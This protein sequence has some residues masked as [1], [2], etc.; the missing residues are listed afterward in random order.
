MSEANVGIH[1]GNRL[2]EVGCN[3]VFA[4]PGDFNL[5]LLDQL[6][7]NKELEMV[8]CCNELNAGYA[9]DGYARRKGIG[10]VVVT[11]CVGGF[12]VINAVSG[13]YSEDLPVICVSGGPNSNDFAS[14]HVL[15]HT[16]GLNN[17]YGQQVRAFREVTCCQ[18]IISH[19]EDAHRQIDLAVSE[20]VKHRKP[21]YIEISCNI[22][23]LFHPS[24]VRPAVPF[25]IEP[26]LS[27]KLSLDAAVDDIAK[28]LN[29]GVKPVLLVG[30]RLRRPEVQKAF[31]ALAEASQFPI[32][33]LPDAKGFVPED[34]PNFC[35]IYWG[36]VSAPCVC[37]MVESADLVVAVGCVWTDYSTV[38]Y[39][40]LLKN[41]KMIKIDDRHVTIQNGTTYSC[42][43]NIDVLKQLATK[44]KVNNTSFINFKR[45]YL[46][47]SEPAPLKDDEPITVNVLFN[48]VQK[49]LTADSSV[50]SEV[51]DSWFNTMK[52]KLPRGGTYELQM[53]YGS[54]GWSVGAVLGYQCADQQLD[55]KRRL[56]AFI[57]DGSFQMTVQEVSTMLR[58]NLKPIIFLI[59]N[60]GY[61]IEVEIHDGPYN[62]IK[63]WNYTGVIEAFQNGE[64]KLWTTKV[65]TEPEF[66]VAL[67]EAI[68][69]TDTL[70][71]IEVFVHKDDCSKE[72]LEWGS[73]VA[74]CNGR[75]PVAH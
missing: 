30:P 73:R 6:I 38:G 43:N 32:T 63:N 67:A 2:V 5:L 49:A 74:T 66:K 15:H 13:A 62:V 44:V 53:R 16:I 75:R 52:M 20:A 46:P 70:C 58:Y 24:F 51:G 29:N 1:L 22:A 35:G 64:G 17:D 19:I 36:A 31:L 23:D 71:F 47:L 39:S 9:A 12:S 3:H 7:K 25:S 10:C 27:N 41:E 54:I 50:I 61:T 57:G 26:P 8:W 4:V 21:V 72:L 11:F 40:L 45:M 37:E 33:M 69:K 59:N 14:N 48:H 42:I 60:G 28:I 18:V 34:H 56:F 65:R 68:K 55:P